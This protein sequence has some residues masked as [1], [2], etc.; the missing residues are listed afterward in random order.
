MRFRLSAQLAAYLLNDMSPDRWEVDF[1][2]V[3]LPID[4]RR[5]KKEVLLVL[6]LQRLKQVASVVGVKMTE[7]SSVVCIEP[8]IGFKLLQMRLTEPQLLAQAGRTRAEIGV[9]A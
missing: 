2:N 4:S 9:I 5:I 8:S 7:Q 3:S 6:T 1:P